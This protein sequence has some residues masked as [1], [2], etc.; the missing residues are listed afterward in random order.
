MIGSLFAGTDEAPGDM[1]FYQG[2]TYKTYRGMGSLEAMKEGNR[3]RYGQGNVDSNELVPEG[4]E[5]MVPYRG[6]LAQVVFQ[7]V[8]GVRAG[9]GYLGCKNLEELRQK[10]EFVRISPQG[11]KE[12]HVHDV[13][14]TKEAPNYRPN[15]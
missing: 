6:E 1:V 9:L 14:V 5:G 7:L 3:D 4:I 13:Y 12:S 2:R 10:A 15:D 8:G 11:L